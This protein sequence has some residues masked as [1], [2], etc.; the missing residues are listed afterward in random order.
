LP[1]GEDADAVFYQKGKVKVAIVSEGKEAVIAL[2]EPD[3][4]CGRRMLDRTAEALGDSLCSD[5]MR[6]DASD[7]DGNPGSL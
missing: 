1:R 4:I 5:G 2:L 6:D 7:K 3:R